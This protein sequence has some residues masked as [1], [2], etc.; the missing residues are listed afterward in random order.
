MLNT[1]PLSRQW[2]LV[3]RAVDEQAPG[4]S[5]A[6]ESLC[7]SCWYPI[8]AFI[9]RSGKSAAAAEN[10]CQGFFERVLSTRLFVAADPEKGRL[11]TFLLTFLKRYMV[12]EHDR[13][14]AGKRGSVR[15]VD[16]SSLSAE[17]LYLAEP[18]DIATP[19]RLY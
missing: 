10:L 9:R 12:D 7:Q 13:V 16:F 8:Y 2:S 11:R 14:Q 18:V 3:R 19:D 15:V 1:L 6:L 17:E 4:S 5:A